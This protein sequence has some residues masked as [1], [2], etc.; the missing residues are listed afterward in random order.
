MRVQTE[1]WR[2]FIPGVRMYKGKKTFFYN[3][4]ELWDNEEREPLVYNKEERDSW[5]VI[6]VLPGVEIIPGW[7]FCNCAK[8][9]K[10]IMDDTVRRIEWGAFE[11]CVSLDFVKLSRNLEYIG[12]AAFYAC[13]SLP[14]IFIPPS[15]REIGN[16]AFCDCNNL[17]ILGLPQHVELGEDIF[18][19]TALIK[20]SP[21]E[22][23]EHGDYENNNE[24]RAIQWVKSINNEEIYSLHRACASYNPLSEIIHDLVKRQGIN[25]IR[26]PNAIG[27]TP[28]QYLQA[29]TFA[30]I[31]EEEIVNKYILDM[32]GEIV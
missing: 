31:S 23:N 9:Y 12:H 6:I 4:E 30:D 32:M 27:I 14:S 26:M 29:N 15:C 22:F 8:I 7:T 20:R 10:V 16:G 19:N 1:E 13:Y 2:R 18:Q 28:S 17:L 11:K 25:A 21:L 5:E 3:G 24:G